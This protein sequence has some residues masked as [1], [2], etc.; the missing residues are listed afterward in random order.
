MIAPILHIQP[1][2]SKRGWGVSADVTQK[3][4]ILYSL[5]GGSGRGGVMEGADL[6]Q[7][8]K[9]SY[10]LKKINLKKKRARGS[11]GWGGFE[12]KIEDIV[13]FK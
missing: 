11:M 8:L 7:V 9:I 4:K 6:N 5:K 13:R 3:L 12:P 2:N 10:N 1:N